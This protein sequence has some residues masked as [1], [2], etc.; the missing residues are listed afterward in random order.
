VRSG[1][2]VAEVV[3]SGFVESQHRGC[4][5]ALDRDGS[6]AWSLGPVEDP[7]FPRSS[8]K[9]IQA[10]GMLR[11]GLELDG[12]L[13][14]LAS[15]SHSGEPFHLAGV[16]R[17]LGRAGLEESALR[18]PADFPIDPVARD[19][20]VRA[21][22]LATP[23]AMNCSGKH[24]AM[25]ATC[26]TAGWPT[27]TYRSPEHPLQVALAATF[28]ELTGAPVAAVGV[29]GCGAP[30]FAT[31][32]VGLATAFRAIV[33]SAEGSPQRRVAAAV[34]EHPEWVS[35]TRRDE[36]TLLRAFP[37]ALAKAGA[38]ACYAV[39]LPDGRAFAVKIDDGGGRARPVVMAAALR[40]SGVEHP[41]LDELATE[42]LLGG[43]KPVG[44]VRATF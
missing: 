5:V 21:G 31:S 12:E 25:L 4:V 42:A 1:E 14:A 44:E 6:L 2:V 30:L 33:R 7:I 32:L 20:Y 27:E 15:A 10:V 3:R 17:I 16:R 34:A 9:P 29:D 38:E 43:G 18:T 19:D 22:G 28:A 41:V 26:V 8:N 39:A 40:R 37:G 11:C 36:V 35:G 13:L 23:I 24:A